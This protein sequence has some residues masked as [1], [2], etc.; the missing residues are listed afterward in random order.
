M[1]HDL[2][3]NIQDCGV[4]PAN[5]C[6]CNDDVQTTR[7]ALDLIDSCPIARFIRRDKLNDMQLVQFTTSDLIESRRSGRVTN[8]GKDNDVLADDEV[9]DES[10]AYMNMMLN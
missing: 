9:L 4:I 6:I 8:A 3:R 10:E 1:F 5:S 7:N 2:E